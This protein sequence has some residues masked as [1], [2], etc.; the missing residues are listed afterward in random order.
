MVIV[1]DVD[2]PQVLGRIAKTARRRVAAVH[3]RG[4][5]HHRTSSIGISVYPTIRD[6]PRRAAEA[7]RRGDVPLWNSDATP[8]SSSMRD[9]AARRCASIHAGNSAAP[10]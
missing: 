10:R 5:R 3:G 7:R 1:E 2:D 4:S 8:S 6:D 9:L